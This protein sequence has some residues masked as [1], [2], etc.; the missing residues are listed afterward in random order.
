MKVMKV[1]RVPLE[2]A[3]EYLVSRGSVLLYVLEKKKK[4]ASERRFS[5][6][7]SCYWLVN[8]LRQPR[9]ADRAQLVMSYMSCQSVRHR[10]TTLDASGTVT[11]PKCGGP[12]ILTRDTPLGGNWGPASD[13][14]SKPPLGRMRTRIRMRLQQPH[15]HHHLVGPAGSMHVTV[16]TPIFK[17]Q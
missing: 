8:E 10:D 17:S 16:E 2:G 15:A 6:A 7:S 12:S 4:A 13:D 3:L 14:I 1:R 9:V 11:P 5:F